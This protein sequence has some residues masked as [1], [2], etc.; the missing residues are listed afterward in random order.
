MSSLDTLEKRIAHALI[1]V[2]R[3]GRLLTRAT[4]LQ[5]P[6]GATCLI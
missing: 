3:C 5:L 6:I 1:I 2:R 4:G